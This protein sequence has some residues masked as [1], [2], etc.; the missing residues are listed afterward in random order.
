MAYKS[1]VMAGSTK[2]NGEVAKNMDL[3]KN[4]TLRA[5]CTRA[6]GKMA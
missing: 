4:S 2:G 3:V 1:G 5:M 6:N